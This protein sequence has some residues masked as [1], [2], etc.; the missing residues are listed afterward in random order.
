MGISE[1]RKLTEIPEVQNKEV[2]STTEVKTGRRWVR[3]ALIG[4][5]IIVVGL[6]VAGTIAALVWC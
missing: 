3:C 4:V 2:S 5:A 1:N 6:I